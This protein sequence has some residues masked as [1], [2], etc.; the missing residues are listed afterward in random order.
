MSDALVFLG[1]ALAISLVIASLH[2]YL[3]MHVL[4]R[5]VILVD[6]SLAQLAAHGATNA[7]LITGD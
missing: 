1:P 3:G 6:L 4:E 2:V 5:E 7:A